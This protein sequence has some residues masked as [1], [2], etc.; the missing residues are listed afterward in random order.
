[1]GQNITAGNPFGSIIT[2]DECFPD[3]TVSNTAKATSGTER[4]FTNGAPL[5]KVKAITIDAGSP[6]QSQTLRIKYDSNM[7]TGWTVY[8]N[9]YI[10]GVAVGT[11]RTATSSTV[12]SEDIPN[13]SSGDLIEIWAYRTG[14]SGGSSSID[15]MMICFDETF[16]PTT[17]TT[18]TIGS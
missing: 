14:S 8:S 1:M 3:I 11:L 5:Q 13:I 7:A 6:L 16:A 2:Q 17:G 10:N 15:D 12:F 18:F 9:I 4:S